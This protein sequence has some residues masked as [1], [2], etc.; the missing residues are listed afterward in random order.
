M[1]LRTP[2][3]SLYDKILLINIDKSQLPENSLHQ[4]S[5]IYKNNVPRSQLINLDNLYQSNDFL[6][7]F[8]DF[9]YANFKNLK[10]MNGV[11]DLEYDNVQMKFQ[12]DP[13]NGSKK[14]KKFK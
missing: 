14:Q 4:Q 2:Y 13:Q 10:N 12:I 5:L 8:N 9:T 3:N 1:K 11:D 6:P 7:P